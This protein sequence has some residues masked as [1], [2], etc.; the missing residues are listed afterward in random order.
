MSAVI[1]PAFTAERDGHQLRAF[2]LG[3]PKLDD[4][5]FALGDLAAALTE[6]RNGEVEL[7]AGLAGGALGLQLRDVLTTDG[8][9]VLVD[10]H[11]TFR[12]FANIASLEDG[13]RAF[14]AA[15]VL[16]EDAAVGALVEATRRSGIGADGPT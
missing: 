1:V 4:T 16:W 5:W 12:L 15:F 13:P 8:P 3:G 9:L 2:A 7:L 10:H 6:T 11:S 14:P